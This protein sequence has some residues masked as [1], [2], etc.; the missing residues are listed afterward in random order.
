MYGARIMIVDDDSNIVEELKSFLQDLDYRVECSASTG[1][2]A[3]QKA[4]A[5]RPDLIIMDIR[6]GQPGFDGIEAAQ[7]IYDNFSIPSVYLTGI[8]D[9][10]TLSR[11]KDSGAFGYILKPFKEKELVAM[12]DLALLKCRQQKKLEVE[13]ADLQ[14]IIKKIADGIIVMDEH[15]KVLFLNPAA[16]IFFGR[17]KENWIGQSAGFDAPLGQSFEIPVESKGKKKILEAHVSHTDWQKKP[18]FLISLRDVTERKN[19]EEQYRRIQRVQNIGMLVGGVVHDLNNYLTVVKGY[20]DVLEFAGNEQIPSALREMR[21]A[22]ERVSGLAK[23]LMV[24]SRKEVKPP[25]VFDINEIVLGAEKILNLLVS[26]DVNLKIMPSRD[27][28]KARVDPRQLEQV[29]INFV[30]NARDAVSQQGKITVE[31]K[32]VV[33]H[34]STGSHFLKGDHVL[35]SIT[36][37]GTG[38]TQ[39]VKDHL[40]EPFFTTKPEG[41]GTGLGLAT[42]YGIIHQYGGD[43]YVESEVGKGT[44]FKIFLP[45]AKE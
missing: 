37:T 34:Q 36:D 29:L 16:E 17:S 9:D 31:T 22:T 14:E 24:F 26:G 8:A 19:A 25:A 32:N 39:E 12:L 42:S 27:L 13:Q 15:G 2:E 23:Q 21:E 33:L 43:I 40:F 45:R 5:M 38:M 3:V 44:T 28:W 11:V 18:A 4:E 30:A 35:I 41:K 1:L 7:K 20:C 10:R 6:L